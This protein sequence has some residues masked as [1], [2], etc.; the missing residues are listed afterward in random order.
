MEE[1][2]KAKKNQEEED[3]NKKEENKKKQEKEDRK[4]KEEEKDKK[5]K[6]KE[7]ELAEQQ[8]IELEQ[9]RKHEEAIARLVVAQQKEQQQIESNISKAKEKMEEGMKT[10][11]NKAQKDKVE[12]EKEVEEKLEKEKKNVAENNRMLMDDDREADTEEMERDQEETEKE[13]EDTEKDQ[14]EMEKDQEDHDEEENDDEIDMNIKKPRVTF[15]EDCSTCEGT[16]LQGVECG[17]CHRWFHFE[18]EST[19]QAEINEQFPEPLF[20]ICTTDRKTR[21][22]PK[23][24]P[25]LDLLLQTQFKM[26]KTLNTNYHKTTQRQKAEIDKLKTKIMRKNHDLQKSQE[27]IREDK[28]QI[29]TLSNER[30][31]LESLFEK[32]TSAHDKEISQHLRNEQDLKIQLKQVKNNIESVTSIDIKNKELDKELGTA[33][34]TV[35]NQKTEIKNKNAV[36]NQLS[37]LLKDKDNKLGKQI[38]SNN[39]MTPENKETGSTEEQMQSLLTDPPNVKDNNVKDHNYGRTVE[40]LQSK[41]T[42]EVTSSGSKKSLT[43]TKQKLVDFSRTLSSSNQEPHVHNNMESTMDIPAGLLGIL[44]GKQRHKQI[45]IEKQHNVSLK[46]PTVSGPSAAVLIKGEK[47]DI[48]NTRKTITDFLTCRYFLATGCTRVNC[49][50]MHNCEEKQ[51]SSATVNT[52]QDKHPNQTKLPFFTKPGTSFEQVTNPK[53]KTYAAMAQSTVTGS[54]E[55]SYQQKRNTEHQPHQGTTTE[56]QQRKETTPKQVSKN[57]NQSP[58]VWAATIATVVTQVLNQ[59]LPIIMPSTE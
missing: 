24:N 48:V 36:I 29:K 6:E 7:Q 5:K 58:D 46:I 45:S 50:F 18:C 59:L 28:I 17:V 51:T 33:R 2:N 55:D 53:V 49:K 30:K 47:K 20:Y 43:P 56:Q 38:P 8:R 15:D 14:E 4:K 1:V 26:L 39:A 44:I 25:P 22:T 34:E 31:E 9:Q 52:M 54:E 40:N 21:K 37:Q 12:E 13:Q 11:Q 27:K 3:Q 19:T 35:K 10:P 57:L 42:D 16:V 23:T 41:P 32:I